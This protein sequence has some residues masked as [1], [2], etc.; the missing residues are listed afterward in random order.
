M[1]YVY[2]ALQLYGP[3]IKIIL[4]LDSPHGLE[5]GSPLLMSDV[6]LAEN[7]TDDFGDPLEGT[8]VW[9]WNNTGLVRGQKILKGLLCSFYFV[10]CVMFAS[11]AVQPLAL[12]LFVVQ[13]MGQKQC[14]VVKYKVMAGS[15]CCFCSHRTPRGRPSPRLSA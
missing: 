5:T 8:S 14:H 10:L 13:D 7:S 11:L 6:S 9:I 3:V 1:P 12:I 2:T 4:A 15:Y